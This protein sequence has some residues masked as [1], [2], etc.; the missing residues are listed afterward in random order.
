MGRHTD[1]CVRARGG[2]DRWPRVGDLRLE[3]LEDVLACPD[4]AHDAVRAVRL[5]ALSAKARA[6]AAAAEAAT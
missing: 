1:E 6:R 5:G 3:E 4:E 2:A